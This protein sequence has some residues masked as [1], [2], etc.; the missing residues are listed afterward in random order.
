MK[1]MFASD[2]HGSAAGCEAMLSRFEAEKPDKLILLGDLLYHGPR[3]DLPER[4]DPKAVIAMLN[5]AKQHLLCVRGNCD[6]EVDQMVL[7]FPVMADYMTMWTDSRMI[8]CTHGHLYDIESMPGI[9]AGD[10][11]ISGHTHLYRAE[12]KNGIFYINTGSVSLPKG[13]NPP[14]YVIYKDR[15]FEVYD[16]E[17]RRICGIVT[18]RDHSGASRQE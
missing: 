16:L 2:I 10:V 9:N 13:G 6:A 18:D 14:T 17:G 11:V 15:V 3:N 4:Y 12:R 1:L 7:D 5:A 8:F